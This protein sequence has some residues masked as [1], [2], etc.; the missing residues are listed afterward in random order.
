MIP[1][2]PPALETIEL[3]A[4][5]AGPVS[6]IAFLR[7][8]RDSIE[9]SR[10]NAAYRFAVLVMELDQPKIGHEGCGRWLDNRLLVEISRRLVGTVRCGSVRGRKDI[11]ARFSG[12]KFAILLE[13]LRTEW[14]AGAV[15]ERILVRIAE[16]F[17]LGGGETSTSCSIGIAAGPRSGESPF[18]I[19]RDAEAAM[20]RAKALGGSRCAVSGASSGAHTVHSAAVPAES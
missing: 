1:E 2:N 20:R 19:L 6:R 13:N 10:Q 4:G 3:E 12:G 14:D 17:S 15:A 11:V 9:R 5:T 7:H 8:L 16:P 18:Q